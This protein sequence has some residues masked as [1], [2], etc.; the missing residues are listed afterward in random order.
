MKEC[1]N[2]SNSILLS[3][4]DI[5]KTD[6]DELQQILSIISIEY[7]KNCLRIAN[8][9]H[10][11]HERNQTLSRNDHSFCDTDCVLGRAST[12]P[13]DLGV[14]GLKGGSK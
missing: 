1:P 11:I 3:P 14:F 2:E 5:Y 4:M 9:V 13:T 6:T 7:T 12:R 8:T 10:Q